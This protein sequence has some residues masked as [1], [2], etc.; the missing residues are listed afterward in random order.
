MRVWRSAGWISGKGRVPLLLLMLFDVLRTFPGQARPSSPLSV[1]LHKDCWLTVTSSAFRCQWRFPD[2]S[3]RRC[4]MWMSWWA[5][6]TRPASG[7][8]PRRSCPL[9]S[10]APP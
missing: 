2:L 1:T 5:L 3:P 6:G 8:I 9:P 4:R 7:T 10:A